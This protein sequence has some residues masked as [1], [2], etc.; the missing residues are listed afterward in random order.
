MCACVCGGEGGGGGVSH[1]CDSYQDEILVQ[2]HFN[3]YRG[4]RENRDEFVLAGESN[5]HK[6]GM[7]KK[8]LNPH[9]IKGVQ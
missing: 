6:F 9:V 3:E 8:Q 4:T 5:R 2:D 1:S 7:F